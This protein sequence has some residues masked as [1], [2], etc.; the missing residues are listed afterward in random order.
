LSFIAENEKRIEQALQQFLKFAI[1]HGDAM[2][3]GDEKAENK[4]H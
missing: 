1:E 4:L 2:Q 3:N